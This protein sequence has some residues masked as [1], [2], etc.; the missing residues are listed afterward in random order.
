MNEDLTEDRKAIALVRSWI[1]SLIVQDAIGYE[2]AAVVLRETKGQIARLSARKREITS[3]L[4]EA[5]ASV[6]DLFRP[7]LSGYAEI[8]EQIKAQ[9]VAFD[10]ANEAARVAAMRAGE[11]VALAPASAEGTWTREHEV[12]EIVDADLVPRVFCSPDLK[13]IRAGVKLG[14]EIPGVRVTKE[15][16]ISARGTK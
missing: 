12:V 13:K 2:R 11:P 7:V 8:E 16:R 1:P 14:V 15:T 10:T 3:K 4:R 6:E 5:L 9:M